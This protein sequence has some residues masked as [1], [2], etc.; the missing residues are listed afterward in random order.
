VRGGGEG[1]EERGGRRGSW[2]V[3]VET[4]REGREEQEAAGKEGGRERNRVPC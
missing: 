1:R 3:E 2:S 4:I